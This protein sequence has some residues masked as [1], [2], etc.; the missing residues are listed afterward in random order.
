MTAIPIPWRMRNLPLDSRGYPVPVVVL[1]DKNGKPLFVVND[2]EKQIECA[3][4]KLCAICGERLTKELWFCGGSLAAFHPRGAY[5]DPPMH[6]ECMRYALQVCPYL[7]SPHRT[8]YVSEATIERIQDRVSGPRLVH[9]PT[10]THERPDPIVAVMSFGQSILIDPRSQ[11]VDRRLRAIKPLRPYHAVEFWR[12][13]EQLRFEHGMEAIANLPSL[14]LAALR[15]LYP[16]PL[17]E[18]EVTK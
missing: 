15:L 10:V 6:H 4:R 7:A 1:R 17:P 2:G 11:F 8:A 18:I 5:L 3:K 13:G 14:D 9:D 16:V 12:H